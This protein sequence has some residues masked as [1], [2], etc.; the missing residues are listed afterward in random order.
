M[1]VMPMLYTVHVALR[2]ALGRVRF[3]GHEDVCACANLRR[4]VALKLGRGLAAQAKVANL[5]AQAL[6]QQQVGALDVLVLDEQFVQVRGSARSQ[7][8]ARRR[9]A[10]KSPT[11][12]STTDDTEP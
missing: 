11:L 10:R 1:M 6:K 7:I 8:Q 5:G 12:F 4:R 9:E 3:G 2:R